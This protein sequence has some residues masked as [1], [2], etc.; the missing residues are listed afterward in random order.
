MIDLSLLADPESVNLLAVTCIVAD[1][2]NNTKRL[3]KTR[4]VLDS[5]CEGEGVIDEDFLHKFKLTVFSLRKLRH[6]CM[7]NG[8]VNSIH[9]YVQVSLQIDQHQEEICLFITKLSRQDIILEKP[10]F[11]R[12]QLNPD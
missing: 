4:A 5:G 1:T 7:V 10:W 8:A 2:T 11:A 9:N 6:I 3:Y 12:H